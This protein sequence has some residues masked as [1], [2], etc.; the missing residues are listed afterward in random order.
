MFSQ[1][2]IQTSRRLFSYKSSQ[3]A[4]IHSLNVVSFPSLVIYGR[5]WCLSD[6]SFVSDSP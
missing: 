3:Y 1:K 2:C 4:P 5:L 6:S